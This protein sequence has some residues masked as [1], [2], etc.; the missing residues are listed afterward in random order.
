MQASSCNGRCENSHFHGLAE[1]NESQL[2]RRFA[3]LLGS[4]LASQLPSHRTGQETSARSSLLF[5]RV[6]FCWVGDESN[7]CE[8]S[9]KRDEL[10]EATSFE[11]TSAGFRILVTKSRNNFESIVRN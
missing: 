1:Q 11:M 2:A 10:F 6:M 7:N 4:H 3:R 8:T 9:G 5:F